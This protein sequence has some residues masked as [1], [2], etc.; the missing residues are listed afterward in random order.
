MVQAGNLSPQGSLP[1]VWGR[2]LQLAQDDGPSPVTPIYVLCKTQSLLAGASHWSTLFAVRGKGP[3]EN[4]TL[5]RGCRGA[6]MALHIQPDAVP[7]QSCFL[8]P[9]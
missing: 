4:M 7:C 3:V 8:S 9:A 5:Q 1:G 6:T 2:H